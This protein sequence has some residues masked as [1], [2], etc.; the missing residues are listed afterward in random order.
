MKKLLGALAGLALAAPMGTVS[1]ADLRLP[2]KAPA[3][4]PAVVYNWTGFYVGG[5][6]GYSWGDA[7]NDVA[8]TFSTITRTRQ[9]RTA[10]GPVP[11]PGFTDVTSA[12]VVAAATGTSK[13][14]FDGVIGGVQT[15]YNW[16]IDRT[17]VFGIET[18]FQGSGER[19]STT[20][21]VSASCLAFVT[22][23]TKLRWF[24]TLRGRIGVLVDP[25]IMLYGTGGLAYGNFD[26]NYGSTLFGIAGAASVNTTRIGWTVGGGIEGALDNNWS[27]KAEYLYADYGR[28]G[29]AFAGV[30][31]TTSTT[32]TDFPTPGF[33]QIIDTTTTLAGSASTRLTDHVFRVGINYRFAPAAV[34]ARY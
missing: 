29:G 20:V 32:L 4:A 14:R 25:R 8:G 13:G 21:C 23:E 7:D 18:D 31:N 5:N 16:Q 33:S 26:L 2:V 1:A 28:A 10:S 27:I 24:G 30:S 19:G 11:G 22:S 17:W 3:M 9:F 34:V 15:G 12:P 6:V